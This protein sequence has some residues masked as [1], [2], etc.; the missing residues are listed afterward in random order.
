MPK[1][2]IGDKMYSVEGEVRDYADALEE[3]NAKLRKENKRLRAAKR[4]TNTKAYTPEFETFWRKFKGRW[5]G[6]RGYVKVGKYEA[7]YEWEKLTE[8]EQDKA[9]V[10]ADS[11]SG[12]YVPDACRWLKRKLF[13][14]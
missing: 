1:L 14:D 5:D 12:K 8:V 13:D 11:V 9:T 7:F 4:K 10:V 3:A 6:D 2:W